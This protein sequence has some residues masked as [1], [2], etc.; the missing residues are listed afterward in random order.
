[1]LSIEGKICLS[2]ALRKASPTSR[3][4]HLHIG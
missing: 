1:M 2:S 4:V 3:R